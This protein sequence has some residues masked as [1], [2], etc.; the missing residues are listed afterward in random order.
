MTNDSED[1]GRG[2]IPAGQPDAIQDVIIRATT[3]S[4]SATL[5]LPVSSVSV[6][7]GSFL[8]SS[9]FGSTAWAAV[10]RS[11]VSVP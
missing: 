8:I 10:Q 9:G 7:E 3:G 6:I 4:T 11:A 1:L 5:N 2:P